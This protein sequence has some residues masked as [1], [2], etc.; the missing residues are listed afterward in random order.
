[1]LQFAENW[2]WVA[3]TLVAVAFMA[4]LTTLVVFFNKR[5]GMSSEAFF[6]AWTAGVSLAFISFAEASSVIST[7]D[8]IKPILPFIFILIAGAVFGGVANVFLAQ[9]IPAAPNPGLPW[10]VFGV[11]TPLAYLFVYWASKLFPG[12]FPAVEFSWINFAGIIA[13]MIGLALVLY[14]PS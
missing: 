10:A 12:S 5:F 14:R 2:S 9:S 8:L 1:M 4:P 13:V 7:K 6:F 3:K 11:S